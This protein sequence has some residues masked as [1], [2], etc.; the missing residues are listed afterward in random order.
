MS[1]ANIQYNQQN[2]FMMSPFQS[3]F[4]DNS[5]IDQQQIQDDVSVDYFNEINDL[6]FLDN[7]IFQPN[8]NYEPIQTTPISFEEETDIHMMTNEE[9]ESK[10]NADNMFYLHLAQE[11]RTKLFNLEQEFREKMNQH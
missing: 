11:Y 1:V 7:D 8:E 2:H 4:D 3:T 6:D 9:L 5:N 10:L